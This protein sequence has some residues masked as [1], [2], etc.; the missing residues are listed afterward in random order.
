MD[1]K[2]KHGKLKKFVRVLKIGDE[3]VDGSRIGAREHEGIDGEVFE[4]SSKVEPK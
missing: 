1:Q 2:L 3:L 4:G